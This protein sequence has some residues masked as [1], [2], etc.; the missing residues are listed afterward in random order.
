M[1]KAEA[2]HG[3]AQGTQGQST[4]G[5]QGLVHGP[6]M[7]QG[8]QAPT[9]TQGHGQGLSQEALAMGLEGMT[10]TL[11]EAIQWKVPQGMLK[12]RLAKL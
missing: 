4:A 8:Q 2:Q 10:V 9:G 11:Q 1:K 7:A 6:A 3:L 12:N 5:P